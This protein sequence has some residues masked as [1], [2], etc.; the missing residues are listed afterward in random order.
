MK[1]VILMIF[2]LL[3]ICSCNKNEDIYIEILNDNLYTFDNSYK[4]DTIN[5]VKFKVVNNSNKKYYINQISF[6]EIY[7]RPS[8]SYKGIDIRLFDSSGKEVKYLPNFSRDNDLDLNCRVY[9]T[10]LIESQSKRLGY[11]KVLQYYAL[12]DKISN[13][14][15]YPSE[16]KYFEFAINLSK[17]NVTKPLGN[18]IYADIQRNKNYYATVSM[19]SDSAGYKNNLPND[20]LMNLEKNNIEIFNGII[21]SKN[22]VDVRVI[23]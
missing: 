7:N 18:R 15:I 5:V 19:V 21:K 8:I 10:S 4:K 23:K 1:N 11:N 9:Q 14:Y 12:F 13:F 3:F 17:G 6:N 2:L 22:K 16:E 20:I